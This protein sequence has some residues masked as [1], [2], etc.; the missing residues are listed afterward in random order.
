VDEGDFQREVLRRLGVVTPLVADPFVEDLIDKYEAGV[1]FKKLKAWKTERARH[2]HLRRLLGKRRVSQLTQLALDEYRAARAVEHGSRKVHGVLVLTSPST[3][4]REIDRL[5]RV[6]NWGVERGLCP[7]NPIAKHDDEE[8]PKGRKTHVTEADVER[9]RSAA[10]TYGRDPR[11]GLTLRAMISTKY[12]G[13]LRR[14]ELCPLR[15]EQLDFAAGAIV[16]NLSET[17]ANREGVR[18]TILSDRAAA[19]V[20]A[21]PRAAGC[22]Y[23]FPSATGKPY[24]PRTWLRM[25]QAVG[26]LAGVRAAEGERLVGHDARAGGITKQLELLTPQRDLMDMV[27][28]VTDQTP[29]YH[30]SR[31]AP[32]VARAKARLE[33]SL[34]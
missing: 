26:R 31:G 4:N 20:R 14:S 25:F 19:D 3:R 28:W 13:M 16:L 29:R 32:A 10:L 15:L 17:K 2:K 22:P 18:I 23:A 8:E 27:G 24:H 21:V 6:V 11:I 30:R 1:E 7:K 33:A 34:R 12:D 5:C 9:L